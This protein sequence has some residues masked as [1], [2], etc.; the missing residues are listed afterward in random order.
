MKQTNGGNF[1][2]GDM[3]CDTYYRMK[4]LYHLQVA[5]EL[6]I[7]EDNNQLNYTPAACNL[8]GYYINSLNSLPDTYYNTRFFNSLSINPQDT[9]AGFFVISILRS[10]PVIV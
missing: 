2:S 3:G 8:V 10:W 4:N 5:A 9:N 6:N 7:Y 1:K